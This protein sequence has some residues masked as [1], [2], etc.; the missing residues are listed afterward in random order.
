MKESAVAVFALDQNRAGKA[1]R[2][3]G[4]AAIGRQRMPGSLVL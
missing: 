2:A 3:W 4:S 1:N